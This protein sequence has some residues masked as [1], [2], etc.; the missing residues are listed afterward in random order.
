MCSGVCVCVNDCE[1]A[2]Y[3]LRLF[4]ANMSFPQPFPETV[5]IPEHVCLCVSVCVFHLYVCLCLS[6]SLSLPL[7][8]SL[9]PSL[10]LSFLSLNL[11]QGDCAIREVEGSI[12]AC[13]AAYAFAVS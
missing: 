6:L 9:S 5:E 11:N 3:G 10:S 2:A 12:P 8:L 4:E 1:N 7:P 13:F